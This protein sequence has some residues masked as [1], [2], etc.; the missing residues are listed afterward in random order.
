VIEAARE[1]D[2]GAETDAGTGPGAEIA[3]VS[4]VAIEETAVAV[5]RG[6]EVG[7]AVEEE[8]MVDLAETKETNQANIYVSLSGI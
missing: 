6:S 2:L 1:V 4:E 3:D 8:L 7:L 5:E